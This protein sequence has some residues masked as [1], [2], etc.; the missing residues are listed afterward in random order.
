MLTRKRPTSDMFVGE[1]NLHKWVNLA[2]PNRVKEVID[3]FFF[4]VVDEYEFEEN[5]IHTCLLSLLHVG[6]SCSKDSLEERPTMREVTMLLESIK[7]DLMANSVDSQ[8][9]GRSISNLLRNTNEASNVAIA[10]NDQSSS[11]M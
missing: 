10:S 3:D 2:F 5:N 8:R 6:L 1:L 7:K 9:L 4:E 11:T